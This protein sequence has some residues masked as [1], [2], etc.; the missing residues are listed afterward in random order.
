MPGHFNNLFPCLTAIFG[1]KQDAGVASV[2][3]IL[4]V[5]VVPL[6]LELRYYYFNC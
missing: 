5:T 2:L 4:R 3:G 6:N 1:T